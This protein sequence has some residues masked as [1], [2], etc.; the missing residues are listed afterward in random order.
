MDYRAS[1]CLS[2]CARHELMMRYY[3]LILC[4]TTVLCMVRAFGRFMERAFGRFMV[5]PGAGRE[6]GL[7][8]GMGGA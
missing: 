8:I 1:V 4:Y 7:R 3:L 5:Y 2:V 6:G